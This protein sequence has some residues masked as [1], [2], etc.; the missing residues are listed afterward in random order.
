[1]TQA[2]RFYEVWAARRVPGPRLVDDKF[3]RAL[4]TD[5]AVFSHQLG[6]RY[7]RWTFEDHSELWCDRNHEFVGTQGVSA[8]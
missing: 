6:V 1:M 3:G 2:Q 5:A 7:H 4:M 8:P